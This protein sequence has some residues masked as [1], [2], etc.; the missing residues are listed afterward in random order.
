MMREHC[1]VIGI[2]SLEG[3]NVVPMI[4]SGLEA[5]QHRGQESWGLSQPCG[6]PIR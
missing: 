5:L 1:G 6:T 2:F 3:Y 4:I